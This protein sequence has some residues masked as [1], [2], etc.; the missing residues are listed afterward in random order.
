MSLS[1]NSIIDIV[2]T[3]QS[4]FDEG[5]EAGMAYS[6]IVDGPENVKDEFWNDS[7]VREQKVIQDALVFIYHEITGENLSENTTDSGDGAV[8]ED[9]RGVGL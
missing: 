9:T 3:L 2:T 6:L 4:L 7:E 1:K 5:W 8:A